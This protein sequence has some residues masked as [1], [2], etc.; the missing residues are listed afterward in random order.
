MVVTA[1]LY[2]IVIRFQG[3]LFKSVG[4][5][6]LPCLNIILLSMAFLRMVHN[7]QQQSQLP[8]GMLLHPDRLSTVPGAALEVSR[9]PPTSLLSLST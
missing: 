2:L 7:S 8:P 3:I 5:V 1:K 6:T 4:L 9:G